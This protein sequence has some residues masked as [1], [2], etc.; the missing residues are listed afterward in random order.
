MLAAQW[1][2]FHKD[3]HEIN[4]DQFQPS[5]KQQPTIQKLLKYVP[6][7]VASVLIT[8]DSYSV[9]GTTVCKE[10]L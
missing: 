9:N 8:Q 7:W 4:D 2:Q 3:H 5:K 6:L 1:T 10:L